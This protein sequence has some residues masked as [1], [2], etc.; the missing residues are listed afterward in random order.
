DPARVRKPRD[1]ATVERHVPYARDSFF[2]GR[3]EE[4][5]SLAVMQADALRWCREVA[6]RRQCRPLER[7]APQVVFDAEEH[8]R[9]L[10]LP[11]DRF[12]L[13]RWSTPKVN[14]D[15]HIKV[16]KALYSVPYQHIGRTVDAREGART[17]QVFLDGSLIKTH[18]RIE[19]GRQSDHGDYPPEKIAFLM[20]TPA[21]CRRRAGELGESVAAVVAALMEV[22][23]LYR[24]RQAQGVVG[25][26][27]KHGPERLEAAC[28][29][30][31]AVGDPSY[32]TV[33]GILAAG[34]E[35]DGD[36]PAKAPTAPAHLR[37]PAGLFDTEVAQ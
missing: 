32:K 9:L 8:Q 28:R 2:A 12:E 29:R 33:R 1:K 36:E 3:E 14:P 34:T 5:E 16:G 11:R 24:L 18:P 10:P 22:N 30:A 15:I 23:A 20:R 37:G 21:W 26:A 35:N 31:L 6:N 4:F 17:V 19:R 27:D 7:V 13:A 25:L